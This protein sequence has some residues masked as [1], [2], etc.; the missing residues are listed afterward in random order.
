MDSPMH[1]SA[2]GLNPAPALERTEEV[3]LTILPALIGF[4]Y[5]TERR[6]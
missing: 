6:A 4:A 3:A 2:L 1:S 5:G